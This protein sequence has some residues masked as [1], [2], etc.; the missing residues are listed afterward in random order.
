M[1]DDPVLIL[2]G[3]SFEFSTVFSSDMDELDEI[4]EFNKMLLI[5][6]ES[7]IDVIQDNALWK[8]VDVKTKLNLTFGETI[9]NVHLIVKSE[10]QVIKDYLLECQPD[11]CNEE[12]VILIARGASSTVYLIFCPLNRLSEGE[13][14]LITSSLKTL[15]ESAD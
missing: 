12:G 6:R 3:Q 5:P 7:C 4:I 13:G 8:I 15:D 9:L 14:N 1:D 11:V 2:E 10:H